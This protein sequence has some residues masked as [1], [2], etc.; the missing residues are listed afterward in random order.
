MYTLQELVNRV[1][2]KGVPYRIMETQAKMLGLVSA[3][4]RVPMN[5]PDHHAVVQAA[6]LPAAAY[7]RYN[8]GYALTNVGTVAIREKAA[9]LELATSIEQQL[10]NG[11][12]APELVRMQNV[13]RLYQGLTATSE[14]KL[15]YEEVSANQDGFD[16]LHARYTDTSSAAASQIIDA[17]GSNNGKNTSIWLIKTGEGGTRM[18]YP[19]NGNAGIEHEP[20]APRPQTYDDANSVERVKWMLDDVVRQ[21]IGLAID[22]WRSVAHIADIDI[23]NIM[24]DSGAGNF[25]D[26]ID[27]MSAAEDRIMRSSATGNAFWVMPER[28]KT[29]LRKQARLAVQ[30]G[31]QLS[32]EDFEGRRIEH[33]GNKPIFISDEILTNMNPVL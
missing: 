31:G 23:D 2:S 27:L 4:Q 29:A 5:Q 10:V 9:K 15:F 22:D 33:F 3:L 12:K 6:N 32:Y 30:A 8:Q 7:S 17:E 11:T 28:V 18:I 26:L 1:D 25:V 20:K 16:G 19:E 24:L 21:D 13:V 14:Q